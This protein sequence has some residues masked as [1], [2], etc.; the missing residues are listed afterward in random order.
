MDDQIIRQQNTIGDFYKSRLGDMAKT[1]TP[2]RDMWGRVVHKRSGLGPIYDFIS[3]VAAKPIVKQPINDEIMRLAK[4][5]MRGDASVPR[6]IGKNT[7]FMEVKVDF[8]DWPHVFDQYAEAAGRDPIELTGK[9]LMET[10]NDMVNG[11][12][13]YG[14]IYSN[15]TS[16]FQKLDMIGGLV[17][18]QRQR[19][20]WEVYNDPANV[21]FKNW[22]GEMQQNSQK[23]K[24]G[25]ESAM[26]TVPFPTP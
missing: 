6:R 14:Q 8:S 20:Q 7:T 25:D 23:I 21:A 18:M 17:E 2:L 16:D 13:F 4:S 24:Q 22:L 11:E 5:P 19:A 1:L 10:L 15:M 12:G 26:E 3:P 9:P